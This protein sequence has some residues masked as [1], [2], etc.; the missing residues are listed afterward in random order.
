MLDAAGTEL[1]FVGQWRT[2][3]LIWVRKPGAAGEARFRE[4]DVRDALS[5]GR[6]SFVTLTSDRSGTTAYLDGLP[7]KHWANARLL[8]GEDTAANKRLVLGNSAEGVFPW[9]GQVLGLAVRAQALTAEQAKESRAWWTNGAGPAAPFAEGLLALYDLR[10]GAGTEVPSR[11]GLGNPLR[12]PRELR[13]QKP[14]LAV[15]DGSHWHTRDFALNVLG[16]VPYGFCLACWL[17]KRWGSCRGPMFVATLA[18]LLVSLAIE[19]VQVSLPTRDSS[20]ADW[21]GNGL[22]TLAGAWLAAR[23]ARHG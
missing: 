6:V 14:L 16:F 12:L 20:L 8:P 18:G 13:E 11:G 1:F 5:T 10:A 3:L 21:A 9:A 7:A 2:E 17:R 23:R 22:G 15:P 19:L 4:M